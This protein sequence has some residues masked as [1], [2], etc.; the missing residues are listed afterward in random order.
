MS[1]D[2]LLIYDLMSGKTLCADGDATNGYF[3]NL[4][5]ILDRSI[6]SIVISNHHKFPKVFC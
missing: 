5:Y 4:L 2:P 3:H 1:F 6:Y